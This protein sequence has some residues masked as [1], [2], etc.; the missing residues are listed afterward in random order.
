MPYKIFTFGL[1][2]GSEWHTAVDCPKKRMVK[3]QSRNA[4]LR[5]T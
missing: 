1:G 2:K 3:I 5:N 4:C